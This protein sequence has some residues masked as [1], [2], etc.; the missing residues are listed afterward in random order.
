MIGMAD[1]FSREIW[2]DR[3]RAHVLKR[4]MHPERSVDEH[5]VFI[6]P[7]ALDIHEALA[8]RLDEANPSDTFFQRRKESESRGSFS[9]VLLSGSDKNSRRRRVHARL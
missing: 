6:N 3:D 7:L 4:R 2:F 5:S 8:D 1:I 9:V